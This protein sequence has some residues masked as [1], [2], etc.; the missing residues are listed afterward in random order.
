MTIRGD[1]QPMLISKNKKSIRR[2]GVEDTLVYLVPEL[3]LMT[4]ITDAMR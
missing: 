4:G 1:R 3:C 2:F